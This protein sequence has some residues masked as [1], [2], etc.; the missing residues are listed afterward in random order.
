[1]E[2]VVEPGVFKVMI[3]SSSEDI[4][5]T[6]S[7]EFKGPLLRIRAREHFFTKTSIS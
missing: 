2:L 6:G 5:L 4:R 3:G 7:F 1:M